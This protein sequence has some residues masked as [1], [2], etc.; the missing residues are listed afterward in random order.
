MHEL[1]Q[2]S[3]ATFEFDRT[4]ISQRDFYFFLLQEAIRELEIQ[5]DKFES[6]IES[7]SA[8]FKKKKADRDVS[9]SQ[10][11][12][13]NKEKKIIVEYHRLDDFNS[14]R[15]FSFFFDPI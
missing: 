3:W 11:K 13:T 10:A 2:G 7:L 5:R 14:A 1:D 4:R 15:S 9:N 12:K 8:T 6:D